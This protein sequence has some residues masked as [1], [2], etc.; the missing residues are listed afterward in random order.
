MFS[1]DYKRGV[2]FDDCNVGLDLNALIINT[3]WFL[4]VSTR[5]ADNN[6]LMVIQF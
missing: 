5:V 3:L 4:V 6:V 2:C 1:E